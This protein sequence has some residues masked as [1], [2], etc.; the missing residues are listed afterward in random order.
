MKLAKV[1]IALLATSS[2]PAVA[3]FEV[4]SKAHEVL[5]SD[6][7]LPQNA[8]GTLAFKPCPTCDYQTVRVNAATQYEVNDRSFDLA[9]FRDEIR[10]VDDPD[11]K[12]ITV[13]HHLA[14][15]TIKAVRVRY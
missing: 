8:N 10:R 15:D 12:T 4:V 1:M 9:A 11:N 2:V 3:D 7:R 13:L 6:L 5:L 14:S